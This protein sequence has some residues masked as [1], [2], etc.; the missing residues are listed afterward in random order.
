MS[1]WNHCSVGWGD[2]RTVN[3]MQVSWRRSGSFSFTMEGGTEEETRGRA[4]QFV[5]ET[6]DDMKAFHCACTYSVGHYTGCDVAAH[7][8]KGEEMGETLIIIV[9][10]PSHHNLL[11]SIWSVPTVETLAADRRNALW[12]QTSTVS[13]SF[14]GPP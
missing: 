5:M 4:T 3:S 12:M 10:R 1:L 14:P 7:E 2:P 11:Q 6:Q 8:R 13:A 9:T